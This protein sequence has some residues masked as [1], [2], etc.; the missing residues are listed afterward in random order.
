VRRPAKM[1]EIWTYLV[2]LPSSESGKMSIVKSESSIC[3]DRQS[4]DW[5][6]E[7]EERGVVV[8]GVAAFE[9]YSHHRSL[10]L[11]A[12]ERSYTSRILS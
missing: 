5:E 11:C 8:D 12:V 9:V 10:D 3:I 7:A 6:E 1:G 2:T 4:L